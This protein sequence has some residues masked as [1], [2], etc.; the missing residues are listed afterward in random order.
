MGTRCGAIPARCCGPC[1]VWIAVFGAALPWC[2]AALPVGLP[3]AAAA[4]LNLGKPVEATWTGVPL[5]TWADRAAEIAGRPVVIDRR[6]DPDTSITLDVRG[7]PLATVLDKVAL[8]A[9]A[10]VVSLRSSIRLVPVKS[11]AAACDRAEYAREQALAKL[12]PAARQ[13]V[14]RR[15]SWKW[16]DGARPRDLV[17][18]A[19]DG[20][21]MSAEGID[22]VP[23]DHFPAASLPPLSLGERLDLVLVHFDL[24]VDWRSGAAGPV[25]AIVA[26]DDSL[27]AMPAKPASHG[28]TQPPKPPTGEKKPPRPDQGR[29]G[30]TKV[31]FTLTAMAPLEEVLAAV[32]GRLEVTL[33]IDRE[34][35]E[36]R[37]ISPKEIVRV[38]VKDASAEELLAALLGPLKLTGKVVGGR[39]EVRGAD[40]P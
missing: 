40:G 4:E 35:L 12:A 6:L 15:S 37:G 30:K 20:A 13:A 23:H 31:T 7:E 3:E 2:W 11:A 8:A 24:R 18:A 22:R 38:A 28:G 32:A 19:L 29:Q 16:P 5:R 14:A 39:L 1:G 10:E 34:A 36:A 17:V 9:G 25:A 21:G 26:I 33:D 27:P